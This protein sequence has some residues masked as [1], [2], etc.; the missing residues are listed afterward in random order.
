[1]DDDY[2]IDLKT[3]LRSGRPACL[4][5]ATE[6]RRLHMSSLFLGYTYASEDDCDALEVFESVMWRPHPHPDVATSIAKKDCRG[7]G[8]LR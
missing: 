5:C 7:L 8:I 3:Q 6:F 4:D 1:M 2:I